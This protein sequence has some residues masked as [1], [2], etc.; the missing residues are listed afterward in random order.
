MK[1]MKI[2]RKKFFRVILE[3]PLSKIKTYCILF[4]V[5]GE[6]GSLTK[7]TLAFGEAGTVLILSNKT[8]KK[9]R[10]YA[11][12]LGVEIPADVILFAVI[13]DLLSCSSVSLTAAITR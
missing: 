5:L 11:D 4:C 9:F 8:I 12:E 3:A 10:E 7:V 13:F 2:N 1:K 6:G